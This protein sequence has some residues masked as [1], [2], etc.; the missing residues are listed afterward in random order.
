MQRTGAV[1]NTAWVLQAPGVWLVFV[2]AATMASQGQVIFWSLTMV[3]IVLAAVIALI[4]GF[5]VSGKR[6]ISVTALTSPGNLGQSGLLGCTFEPDIRMGSIAIRWAKA[7][8]AG[9]VHEFRG[10][11]DHLQEQDV[12]FQGRT[13]VFADQVIGGNAS[14]ELRDVKL[15]DA[16]TYRCSVTTSRG[17][18]VAELQYQTGAFS[19]PQVQVEN[20]SSGDTLQCEAPRWFPRPTVHWTAYSD[21]G[22]CLPRVANTSYELNSENITLKVVS[23]LHNITANATYT[24]VIENSIAKATGDIKVTDFS[25]TRGT[26]L[27]LVNLNTESASSSLPACH[28]MLLLPVCLLSV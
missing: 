6:S 13:A 11:K 16:G 20:S 22:K 21:T 19:T 3:I 18:G 5:G 4:I 8:V 12:E 14:L 9:L 1:L 28:W 26:N 25:I 2:G 17:S 15:S 27:Q 7:G 10:G 23:L 24:C